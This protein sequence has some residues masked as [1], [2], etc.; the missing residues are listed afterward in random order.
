MN[1]GGPD[2]PVQLGSVPGLGT[3]PDDVGA[4]PF[5]EQDAPS[6]Q[7]VIDEGVEAFQPGASE[8][9]ELL[10]SQQRKPPS[11]RKPCSN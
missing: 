10:V 7:E 3:A 1:V 6:P 9:R 11:F 5:L 4:V 2:A 8:A